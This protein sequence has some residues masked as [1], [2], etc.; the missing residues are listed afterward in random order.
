MKLNVL[1]R[2]VASQILPKEGSFT[3][4]KL[5][6]VTK[7]ELSFTEEE[8]KALEFTQV[9]ERLNWKEGI[10][11]DKEFYFGEVVTKLIVDKLKELDKSEDLTENHFSLYE[12]FIGE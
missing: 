11:K 2:I 7:E 6:R 1:E 4:L 10:V 3:N 8:N 12:K 5:I 9:G